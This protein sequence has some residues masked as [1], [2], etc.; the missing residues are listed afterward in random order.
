MGRVRRY[1]K[2]KSCDP[3]AKNGPK[4]ADTVHDEPVDMF[5]E[6]ER[7]AEKRQRKREE[8]PEHIERMLQ[9]EAIRQLRIENEK[10]GGSTKKTKHE[11]EGRKEDERKE[12]DERRKGGRGNCWKGTT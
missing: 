9:R 10:S 8:D 1:K 5:E 12:E 3:F 2:F 7:R 11:L 6:Q 4:V